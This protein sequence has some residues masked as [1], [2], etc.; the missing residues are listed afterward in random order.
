LAETQNVAS[1]DQLLTFEKSLTAAT[2]LGAISVGI[3]PF[4]F[5]V[6]MANLENL[7][8]LQLPF[9]S[10]SDDYKKMLI[11]VAGIAGTLLILSVFAIKVVIVDKRKRN[12]PFS[13][14]ALLTYEAGYAAFTSL[15]PLLVF[16]F[17]KE[18]AIII[19]IIVIA[20][21]MIF[22]VYKVRKE[23][24]AKINRKMVEDKGRNKDGMTTPSK[25]SCYDGVLASISRPDEDPVQQPH[26]D[27]ILPEDT[28]SIGNAIDVLN[29]RLA[30]GEIKIPDYKEL[31]QL[32]EPYRSATENIS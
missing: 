1:D 30:K 13:K 17:S 6:D 28:G 8:N 25:H 18:G 21:A 23:R 29:M 32:L 5:E 16:P 20:W 4:L 27:T 9:L 31:R 24:L 14:T 2:F 10:D 22:L 7:Q 15:L 3:L 26:L 12:E 11:V 19:F